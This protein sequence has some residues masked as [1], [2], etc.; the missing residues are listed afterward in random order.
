MVRTLVQGRRTPS[1]GF[2][3]CSPVRQKLY[4]LRLQLTARNVGGHSSEADKTQH[5][6]PKPRYLHAAGQRMI[7]GAK[8]SGRRKQHVDTP[9][10][11]RPAPQTSLHVLPVQMSLDDAETNMSGS[12]LGKYLEGFMIDSG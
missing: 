6:I 5:S 4:Q 3:T 10:L 1:R 8:M 7:T 12:H 11:K 9:Q 2:F